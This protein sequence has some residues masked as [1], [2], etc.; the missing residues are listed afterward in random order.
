MENLREAKC[1][2]CGQTKA[3]H[4]TEYGKAQNGKA[5]ALISNALLKS[6]WDKRVTVCL[7]DDCVGE[8]PRNFQ[9]FKPLLWVVLALSFLSVSYG[10]YDMNIHFSSPDM[11]I[12][13]PIIIVGVIL[14]WIGS[15]A[16]LSHLWK[17]NA[18]FLGGLLLGW[19]PIPAIIMLFSIKKANRNVWVNNRLEEK[20]NEAFDEGQKML[21]DLQKKDPN[22]L[23]DE[24]KKLLKDEKI[25]RDVA[26]AAA[27]SEKKSVNG[28]SAGRAALGIIITIG[29]A[30]WG[31]STF[32]QGNYM[33]WFGIKLSPVGFGFL[34]AA[35]LIYD[36]VTIV[37]A[38][39]E[40]KE[41]KD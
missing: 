28:K 26:E 3:C 16:G 9:A 7:C 23:S 41:K 14:G 10:I 30:I 2:G 8:K 17:F 31:I 13:F 22:A 21:S 5:V 15:A 40:R 19:T 34:I 35:F 25:R 12:G 11:P 6:S 1:T 32:S 38:T 20:A 33:T 4:T 39:K 36:I 18:A 37:S 29:I 24:E 27:A